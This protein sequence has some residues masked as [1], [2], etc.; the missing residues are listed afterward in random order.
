MKSVGISGIGTA[1]PPLQMTQDQ[2]KALMLDRFGSRLSPRN[3]AVMSRVFSHPSIQRRSFAMDRPDEPIDEDQDA[4]IERFTRW[5]VDLG[6]QAVRKALSNSG[7]TLDDVSALIVNTCTGYICPGLSTYLSERLS[8][9]PLARLYDLVGAG[10]GGAI[11]N[12]QLADALVRQLNPI[13]SSSESCVV[14]VS[15]EICT[16]T[17]QM[18]DELSL[19]VSNALF[20]DGA[21]AVCVER[22]EHGLHVLNFSSFLDASHRDDI[23]YVYKGGQLHNQL[24]TDLPDIAGRAVESVVR[25][26]LEPQGLKS[27]DIRY[28][29]MHSGGDKVIESVRKCL[30]L[31]ESAMEATRNV[32]RDHGNMSS[33]TPVFALEN[34][35][36]RGMMPGDH[37]V[38][39]GFGAGMSAHACLLRMA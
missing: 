19:I 18:G 26:L 1:S 4:K 9:N 38:M 12:L 31:P 7:R 27:E 28:W 17:F 5:A 33:P 32:L 36:V 11:P 35:R 30:G 34:L 10:C 24:S 8:L 2:A 25:A 14:S 39:V 15:I 6:C 16:A 20:G 13:V 23:R 21:A 29:A 37:C 22:T 3:R